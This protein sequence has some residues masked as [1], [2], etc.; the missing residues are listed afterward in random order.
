MVMQDVNHQ[1]F[2]ESVLE[3]VLLS[4]HEPDEEKA[5]DILRE[6]DLYELKDL[7]PMS[8]SGGQKQRVAIASAVASERS[9]I[10]FDEPTSGLDLRHMKEVAK[11]LI[12][13]QQLGKTIFVISHDPELIL[14]CCNHVLR[15]EK[16]KV[17]EDYP[18][19][20]ANK[21]RLLNF[22]F[23]QNAEQLKRA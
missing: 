4:M 2:T 11:V 18:L 22:F 19:N 20:E 13:L 6:L 1:L 16:G 7:H 9:V 14:S 23:D 8:L 21:E 5:L 10:L 12:Y 3:E 17:K 15:L